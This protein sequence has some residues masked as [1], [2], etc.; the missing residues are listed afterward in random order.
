MSTIWLI[1][2]ILSH[3]LTDFI[4]QPRKWIDDRIRKHF[5]SH[6]LYLHS[7]LT[8]AVALIF[9]GWKYWYYAVFIGLTHLLIDGWKSYRP[10]KIKYFLADQ[11]LHLLVIVICWF[12]LFFNWSDLI[13][14]WKQ[15]N[16]NTHFWI[17]SVAFIFISFPAGILVGQ[18]TRQWSDQLPG[19]EGLQNAGKWIGILERI[20]ILIFLL[21][22]QYSVIGLL[23]TAKGLLRFSEKDRQEAKTEYVL[24]GSL[25]SILCSL[26]TGMVVKAIIAA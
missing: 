23:I 24:I 9:I 26:L 6:W 20:L 13:D 16:T 3:L 8:G 25:I 2:L 1:K 19:R 14:A 4:L 11:A 5:A 17:L 15:I 22:D 18:M 12:H 10:A 21:Q 7:F